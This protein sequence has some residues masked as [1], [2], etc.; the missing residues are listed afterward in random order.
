MTRL[1]VTGCTFI[2][3]TLGWYAGEPFGM[4]SAFILSIV[5]LGLGVF[6][7]KRLADRWGM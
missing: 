7:G 3:S 6:V 2:L 1:L 5:G 4:F